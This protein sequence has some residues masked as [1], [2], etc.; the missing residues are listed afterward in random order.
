MVVLECHLLILA[1][2]SISNHTIVWFE[3]AG[4]Y[5]GAGWAY[6]NGTAYVDAKLPG[7]IRQGVLDHELCHLDRWKGGSYTGVAWKEELIC[8][9]RA[10]ELLVERTITLIN[11]SAD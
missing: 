7:F 5:C 10:A 11:I 6:Q 2:V 3:P 8:S 1:I 9:A 4:G